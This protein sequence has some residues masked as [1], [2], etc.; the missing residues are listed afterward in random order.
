MVVRESFSEETFEL[1]LEWG[2]GDDHGKSGERAFQAEGAA[3]G[4]LEARKKACE[5]GGLGEER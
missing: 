1:K 4:K 2:E 5:S 3:N